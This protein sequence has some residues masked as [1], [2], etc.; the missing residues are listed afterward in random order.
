MEGK[1]RNLKVLD[2]QPIDPS[3]IGLG[4]R[5]DDKELLEFVDITLLKLMTTGDYLGLLEKWFGKVRAE[6]LEL[7]LKREIKREAKAEGLLLITSVSV[8]VFLSSS[9]R[10][11]SYLCPPSFIAN[12]L[13]IPTPPKSNWRKMQHYNKRYSLVGKW[14]KLLICYKKTLPLHPL[15][16]GFFCSGE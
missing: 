3:P 9:S 13:A 16:P 6:F 7:A 11:T 8:Y 4:I 10:L 2:L 12:I 1:E 14:V 5:K 15:S